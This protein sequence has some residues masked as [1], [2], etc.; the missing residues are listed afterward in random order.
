MAKPAIQVVEESTGNTD[1]EMAKPAIQVVE[2]S[3]GNNY[4]FEQIVRTC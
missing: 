3:T 1:C 2:E 4:G